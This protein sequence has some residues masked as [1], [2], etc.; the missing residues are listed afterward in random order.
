MVLD[1]YKEDSETK[2]MSRAHAHLIEL[3]QGRSSGPTR[4]KWFKAMKGHVTYNHY[5]C[6]AEIKG[7]KFLDM[8]LRVEMA[9]KAAP[10]FKKS[11][12][13]QE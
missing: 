1:D 8:K 2:R 9:D 13:L 7:V 10:P 6:L 11:I 12:L 4:M 5:N 3:I